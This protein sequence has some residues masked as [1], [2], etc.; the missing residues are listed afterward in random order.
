MNSDHAAVNRVMRGTDVP[1]GRAYVA[2]SPV[3]IGSDA[4]GAAHP[5]VPDL[6]PPS[7]LGAD[8]DQI[9]QDIGLNGLIGED[10]SGGLK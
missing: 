8:T 6:G 9:L 5:D 1:D 3:Q 7:N 2:A 4:D 10:L